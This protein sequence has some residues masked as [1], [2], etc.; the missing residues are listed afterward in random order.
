MSDLLNSNHWPLPKPFS[1]I[2]RLLYPQ[3]YSCHVIPL[4]SRRPI[5]VAQSYPRRATLFSSRC[6]VLVSLFYSHRAILFYRAILFSLCYQFVSRYSVSY[7]LPNPRFSL[8]SWPNSVEGPEQSGIP[9]LTAIPSLLY[10]STFSRAPL[11]MS[12][13]P[14][15]NHRP[16]L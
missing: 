15:S 5:L 10:P 3:S 14:I 16:N 13:L 6:P 9:H 4:S 1:G 8:F 7:F 12:D 11:A 2:S